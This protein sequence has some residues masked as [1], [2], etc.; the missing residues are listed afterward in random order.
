MSTSEYINICLV[1]CVSAGKSTI[2]NA[3][4]SNNY[5]QCKIKRTTMMPNKFI[6][7]D[8]AEIISSQED[9]LS[10]IT[11]T[12]KQIY[13]EHQQ[14]NSNSDM[15]FYVE[16]MDMNIGSNIKICLWDIPG[17]NDAKTKK[18]YYDY[19]K[20]NFEKFNI[21]LFVVDIYSGLNTS[22]EME[23]LHFLT[24]NIVKHK[25]ISGNHIKLLAVIN[26]A[27]DMQLVEM[28]EMTQSKFKLEVLGELGEMFQ[29]SVDTIRTEFS[30]KDIESN[31][32]DI[33]PICGLDANLYRMIKKYQNIDKLT[34]ENILRIGVNEEGSKF[35]RYAKSEQKQRVQKKIC[36]KNFVNDM[37]KFSGFEQI[38]SALETYIKTNGTMMI[39]EN[40][41]WEYQKIPTMTKI[42]MIGNIKTKLS[43]LNNVRLHSE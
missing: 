27:D 11:T 16:H 9:I 13:E 41:I 36:D 28:T 23:I 6:E 40:L 32:L 15:T 34:E 33:I 17:L 14:I 31:L 4:F 43:V 30:E 18:V 38:E 10:T 21:I 12:N 25:S 20:K 2:L 35:R 22:D 29:Q 26:K 8:D 1:G 24:E 39:V 19:L 37:I 3:F 42:N 7:S 5:A